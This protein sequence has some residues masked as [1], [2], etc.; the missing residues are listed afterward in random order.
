M[1]AKQNLDRLMTLF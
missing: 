1:T